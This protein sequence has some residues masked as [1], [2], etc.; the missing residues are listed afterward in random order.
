MREECPVEIGPAPFA[1]TGIHVEGE[2]GVPC[3]FGQI[4]AG[5]PVDADSVCARLAAFAADELALA[6]GEGVE[7]I[8]ERGIAG[9]L[10]MELLVGALQKTLRG[11]RPAI[12]A[13]QEG[14]VHPGG[15][16]LL[17]QGDQPLRQRRAHRLGICVGMHQKPRA[18]RRRERNRDL[19]LRVIV[20]ARALI[21]VRPGMVEDIFALRMRF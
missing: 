4:G 20:A 10:P 12:L 11:Q 16:P 9:I 8:L 1:R 14:G 3:R 21:G 19:Q 17:A 15:L 18:G 5:Q 13:L 2:E 7:E 6:R